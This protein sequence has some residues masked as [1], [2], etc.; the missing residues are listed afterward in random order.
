MENGKKVVLVE[1]DSL[2]AG[3]LATHL[4][5]EGL[6]VVSVTDGAKAFERIKDEHPD[7]VLLDIILPSMSGFDVLQ[8]LKQDE[9]TKAIPVLIISNLGSKEEIQKGMS[10]GAAGYL[11]KANS[12]VEEITA[13]AV[14]VLGKSIS[15]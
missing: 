15:H 14:E 8:K 4:I 12:T 1:D 11:V 7:I 9:T 13:K 6:A 5:S 10:L 3:I 2:M